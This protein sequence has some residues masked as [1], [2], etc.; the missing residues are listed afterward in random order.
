MSDLDEILDVLD[1]DG[2]VTGRKP[3]GLVH[4]DHDR[5]GLVFVWSAWKLDGRGVMLLQRRG[6]GGDPFATQVDA[7]AGG[8]IGA[9][10]TPIDAARRELLEEVGATAGP[11]DFVH[12]GSNHMDRPTGQCRRIVQHQLLYP[13]PLDLEKLTFSPEVDGLYQVDLDEFSALV[14]GE[15]ACVSA[16]ARLAGDDGVVDVQLPRSAVANYP[17]EI[18]DTFRRSLASVMECLEDGRPSAA[19]PP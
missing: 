7:L 10:E 2:K 9:G 13:I 11:D 8:H 1:D 16:R 19:T 12:L 18:L 15:R 3:R 14:S 4:R 5:H 17:D 6:R